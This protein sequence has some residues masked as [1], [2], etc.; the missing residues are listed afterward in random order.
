MDQ[1]AGSDDLE[2]STGPSFEWVPVTETTPI[3]EFPSS[4]ENFPAAP[5]VDQSGQILDQPINL[6]LSAREIYAQ[7]LPDPEA[8][9]QSPP[10]YLPHQHTYRPTLPVP[11]GYPSLQDAYQKP[12]PVYAPVYAPASTGSHDVSTQSILAYTDW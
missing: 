2:E 12:A 5:E 4:T 1:S 9:H 10:T 11:E 6:V 3:D 8:R 7:P